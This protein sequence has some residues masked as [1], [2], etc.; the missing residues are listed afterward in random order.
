MDGTQLYVVRFRD[1]SYMTSA[2]YWLFQTTPSSANLPEENI[3]NAKDDNAGDDVEEIIDSQNTHQLV[4]V[5][6]L[7]AEPDD[8][9]DVTNH[10][11]NTN[12]NL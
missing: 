5:V 8:E 12:H 7:V 11:S 4:E 10:A 6:P 9:G 3:R 1:P 2:K